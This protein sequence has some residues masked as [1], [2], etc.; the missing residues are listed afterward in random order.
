[1]PKRLAI[2][3][4][5]AERTP[6]FPDG[7]EFHQEDAKRGN[8]LRHRRE[9]RHLRPRH[10]Q[11]AA[12]TTESRLMTLSFDP[13]TF[14]LA[15]CHFIGGA[16]VTETPGMALRRPSD[17]AALADTPVAGVAIVDRAV[18]TAQR[19]L[20][21]SG[22]GTCAAARAH[23]RPPPLGRPYR[24]RGGRPSP[25]SRPSASTRP[26]GQLLDGDIAVTAE[27]IRFFAEF[28]D[29]EGGDLV[30]TAADA[31]GMTVTEPYGV[32]GAI[33]PWNFPLS[34]AGWKLGPALA[35]G[36][37]V[38]LKPSEMTPF[39][40]L[41]MAELA[42]RAGIPAG[43]INVVLGDGPTTGNCASP[44]IPA[45]PRSAS[46]ARPAPARRSWTTSPAPASSR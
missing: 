34:M 44:A 21:S 29:K 3:Q 4:F 13:D 23:P 18:E 5:P 46:P 2:A 25:G 8:A 32:V 43:L 19:A 30:P 27:Q 38:V 33:T 39:S 24:G 10:G 9:R 42:V 1:M 20:R 11:S 35:A 7:I 41:Y 28:A 37:A 16:A 12:V 26:V 36:N 15:A 17:G 6:F 14:A 40:T 31:L 45:S 22:W